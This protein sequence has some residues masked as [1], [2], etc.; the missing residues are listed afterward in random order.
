MAN[1]ATVI[2]ANAGAG[3]RVFRIANGNNPAVSVADNVS[4]CLS[5]S[6]E[7]KVIII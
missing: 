2:A 3:R 5:V 7:T 1:I 6:N 4:D